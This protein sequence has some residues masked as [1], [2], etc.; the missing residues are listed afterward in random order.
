MQRKPS[1]ERWDYWRKLIDEQGGSGESVS[2]FCRARGVSAP[3]FYTWRRRLAAPGAPEMKFAL[4][5]LG[6]GGNVAPSLELLLATGERLRI[7]AG[8]DAA[9]LRMVLAVLRERR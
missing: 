8:S 6:S 3:S 1:P 7:A 2:T 4:V 5:E 9:T